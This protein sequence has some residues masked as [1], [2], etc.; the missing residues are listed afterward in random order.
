M[1]HAAFSLASGLLLSLT[2]TAAATTLYVDVNN[3]AP[4]APYTNWVTAATNIQDAVD[5]ALD[6]D[7]VL[8]TNGVYQTGARDVYGMSN[9]VTLT[10]AVTVQSVNGSGVTIIRGHGP[11]GAAAVRCVYLTNG[12]V[13]TGF[14]LTNGAT[15][16]FGDG[17]K[18]GSGGGV[19]CESTSAVVSNC[20]LA[21][22]SADWYGGGT[23]RGVLNNCTL[24]NNYASGGG[25]EFQGILNKC[26][27]SGNR[28]TYGGGASLGTLNDCVLS[29][30]SAPGGYGGGAD[31]GT[32]NNCTF[33]NNWAANGGGVFRGTLNNCTVNGNWAADGGGTYLADLNGCLLNGNSATNGSGGG[34]YTGT[35]NNCTLTGNSASAFGGGAYLG[36]LTSCIVYY[37][38][39][40]N[41]NDVGTLNY[42]CTTPLPGISTGNFTNAPLF[43]DQA[44]GDFH[45]QTN[46]PCIN[47]GLNAY[48]PG[49]SDLEGH[50]RISGG[51][52]DVGAYEFQSPASV[53]SYAWLQSYGLP[54][55]GLADYADTD[56][57]G[58]N[59]WQEWLAGTNPTNAASVLRLQMPAF[60]PDGV[61]LTWSSVANRNYFVQR[62]TNLMPPPAFSL[63]QSNIPGLPDTT[64]FTNI[65]AT[66]AGPFLYRVGVQQ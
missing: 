52:V 27:L 4:A 12:A 58:M 13:L 37:N 40:L 57:D 16:I 64:S 65:T 8:V 49:A 41:E 35:L 59:N 61:M 43:V 54:M 34:A 38:T 26:T 30:N 36:W 28:G 45:L 10:K 9:R 21:G 23:F 32:F 29:G 44:G 25:G 53:I 5:T 2:L 22:N 48:A 56:N 1:K 20:V 55:D 50:P 11:I 63:L 14:T 17:Y 3:P 66:N 46:S 15:Q 51:T 42:C 62:A 6:G 19:W 39:A 47:A 33:S 7:Q 18:Q 60:L 24:L 31:S